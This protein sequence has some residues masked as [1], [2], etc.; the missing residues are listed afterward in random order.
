MTSTATVGVEW[1]SDKTTVMPF[2]SE[3][4]SKGMR[5]EGALAAAGACEK[6]SG[7]AFDAVS[8]ANK[9]RRNREFIV[10]RVGENAMSGTGPAI[11]IMSRG[12]RITNRRRL[13]TMLLKRI[14]RWW[15][16]VWIRLLVGLMRRPGGRPDWTAKPFRALFLRHDRA[17]DM[18]VSTGVMRGIVQA[19]PTATLDV[20]ASP[21][22]AAILDEAAYV[23]DVVVFDKKRLSSYLPTA[24]R[25][26][27][28]HYDVVIDCMVT[29]PSVTTLLLILASGA[30]YR[31]GIAGR[32]NDAA[33]NVPVDGERAP[34][35]H[36]VDRIAALATAFRPELSAAERQPVLEI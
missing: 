31:V 16:S 21:I 19:L 4:F 10:V 2:G 14:E 26:R 12:P 3:Y 15:R 33:F 23:R 9:T 25:L 7:A 20:L 8:A 24:R 6:A 34:D 35:A 30:R 1:S 28:A 27:R 13:L 22:N 5:I 32:G 11:F 17:G 29:A 36:M 18:I